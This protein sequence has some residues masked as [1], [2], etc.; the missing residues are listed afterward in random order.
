MALA[1]RHV[2]EGKAHVAAQMQLVATMRSRGFPT[3]LAQSILG[4]MQDTLS[5]MINH[6]DMIRARR[7]AI[8]N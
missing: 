8:S 3:E 4:T 6:R 7:E 5:V 2:T 1:E